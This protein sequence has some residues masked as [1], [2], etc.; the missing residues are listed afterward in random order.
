MSQLKQKIIT[1]LTIGYTFI[2]YGQYKISGKIVDDT[3]GELLSNVV[4]TDLNS[5][6]EILSNPDGSFEISAKG[7]YAFKKLGYLKKIIEIKNEDYLIVQLS[8]DPSQ[9]N[10]VI[11]NV[12]QLPKPL[13]ESS[14]TISI[15]S[16]KDIDRG[17]TINI[18]SI[19]NRAPGV[20]MQSGALNTN[21]ITIRGV[22]ARN[23][24]GTAK[25]RAYFKDIPLT[26][27]SGGT[28]IE[29]FELASISRFEITKGASS[30]YGAGLGGT[31]Q[32]TPQSTYYNQ[33][34]VN[35]E[36]VFGSF[37]LAKGLISMNHGTTKN[38]FKA[39]FS[40]THSDGYRDNNQY[41]RQTLT[42]S[43]NH[44]LGE[45]DELS[46]LAS[47]VDLNAFIPSSLSEDNYLNDPTSAAFTWG[48]SKG[49]EDAQRGILGVSWNHKY[50]NGL[51][52]IT[53]VFTSFREGYEPRPFNI[54][55]ESTFAIGIRSR[56]LGSFKLFEKHLEWT[57]GGELFRDRYASGTFVNL[58]R[59]FPEGH[60]SVQ[61]N[62][63]SDFKEKRSYSN[64]F[65]E[66]NYELTTN[67]TVSAGL[68]INHTS[69][70]LE[71]RFPVSTDN[72]DQSGIFRF[73][74]I[75]SPKFGV[76][77]VLSSNISIYTNVS[78]GFSPI[79]LEETL[80]PD[81]Q[82]NTGLKPET[83]WNYEVGTRGLMLNNK[84]QFNLAIYRLNIK[85]LLVSRRTSEDQ[86]I[87]INAGET[88]HDG[89]ELELHYKWLSNTAISISSFVN[90]TLNDYKFKAFI[91]GD[92]NFSGNDLTGVPSE[93]FNT[94]IDF[95]S[96][97]GI[98][99]NLNFQYVGSMPI[100][101]SNSLYS[102]NYRLTNTK[103]GYKLDL[104]E[105]FNLNLYYGL[106]NLFDEKYASQ[107]LINTSGFGGSAPRYYYPGNPINQYGGIHINYEF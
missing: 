77:Q 7:L 97:F 73:D 52:Q 49:F 72:P 54:L 33:N 47:Y 1:V 13:K 46:V 53:S 24:F 60:G 14:N 85:N 37:G 34:S 48:R 44:Y 57:I 76:S 56:L 50:Q 29:D 26:S 17:N 3:H 59:D 84:L 20:F 42:F 67:T 91:D 12:N 11:I 93:V 89:L 4:I 55:D 8:I 10:E 9:L 21:R 45:N 66:T 101:D 5:N 65:F 58:Y 99:A 94:G 90:Y 100:T 63:L 88:Q 30:I 15:L 83:G 16:K 105:K 39:V 107:I 104:S 75:I 40:N 68:N 32:L 23:L 69:Y 35:S 71:D 70:D 28:T 95:I 25:I 51:K 18:A 82:I 64:I 102:D 31:I 38:S 96:S 87:G 78:H 86:F 92:D 2:G 80:L 61:G 6:N 98:Y 41:D 103:F 62:R 27:G 106:N 81:G 19:L 79:T 36:F 43:S 74:G 22:G